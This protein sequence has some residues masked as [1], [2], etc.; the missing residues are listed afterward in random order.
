MATREAYGVALAK[1]AASHPRVVALDCDVKNST[2]SMNIMKVDPVRFIECF[3]C[4]QNMVGVGIGVACR[5][6]AVFAFFFFFFIS[7]WV[8]ALCC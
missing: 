2:F 8:K 1:L 6:A 4:E 7:L 3:I 5:S